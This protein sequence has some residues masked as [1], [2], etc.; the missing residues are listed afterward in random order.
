LVSAIKAAPASEKDV[1][2]AL[3]DVARTMAELDTAALFA[4]AGQL[5]AGMVFFIFLNIFI[6]LFLLFLFCEAGSR[7]VFSESKLPLRLRKGN[8]RS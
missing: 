6:Y 5:E 4:A 2:K 3:E 8:Y 7:G 1:D